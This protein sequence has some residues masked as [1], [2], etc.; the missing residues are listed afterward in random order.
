M[1]I[2]ILVVDD[3]PNFLALM[4]SAL[5]RRGFDVNIAAT[6]PTALSLLASE[7]FAFALVDLRLGDASG[8]E[9]AEEI[10]RRSPTTHVIV[11][12]ASPTDETRAEAKRR[13]AD[14]YLSKPI[15]LTELLKLFASR[16]SA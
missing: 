3:E 11:V 8:M 16:A 7:N 6:G 12:T 2:P 4:R 14:D 10:K 13:G 1:P 9:L 15:P 5:S